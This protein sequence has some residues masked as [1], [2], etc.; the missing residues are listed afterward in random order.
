MSNTPPPPATP[1][2]APAGNAATQPPGAD[3]LIIELAK[4]LTTLGRAD[5]A[6]RAQAAAARLRRPSTVVCVVGEFKQGKSSLINSLLGFPVCPV[7][8]D[9]ATSA[10]T[11]VRYGEQ[12]AAVV[13][14]REGD[15]KIAEP[16]PIARVHEFVSESGNPGN[17]KGVERV[18][19]TVPSALLKQ[20]L[21]VVDTPGM[22]G[23]GAGHAAATLAFL[24]FADGLIFASDA[25]AE[26]S[27]PEVEFLRRAS[28][29]CPTVLFVQTKIDL[30]PNWEKIMSLN[31]GHMER[32]GFTIAMV[33]V[34]SAL[35]DEALR[36]KDRAL[37]DLSR[38]P[39]V[40]KHL[41]D[42]VV[43]PAK[44]IA[45]ERSV[46]DALSIISQLTSG[47][48]AEKAA[49][50]DPESAAAAVAAFDVAKT[51]LEY[52]RGPAAKWS[53]LVGD[54]VSD[55][56]TNVT[57]QFRGATRQISRMMD[58]R[59]EVLSKGDEWDELARYL[60]TVVADEVTKVFVQLE[61]GRSSVRD[62]VIELMHDED[63]TIGTESRGVSPFDLSDLWSDKELDPTLSK[64]KKVL[65]VSL[66][67]IRG[68]QGGVMMFGML[69]SFLPTAAGVLLMS[70]PVLL[71]V[72]A[73][74]GSMGLAEDRKKKVAARRQAARSQVRQFM[75]DVQFE[76][77]NKISALV[78]DIQRDLRDEFGERLA[79]LVRTCTE[80]ATRVQQDSQKSAAERKERVTELDTSLKSFTR[81]QSALA[82]VKTA[83][84][85]GPT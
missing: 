24:P 15:E 55:L 25:S 50:A 28:E 26:L 80:S 46:G 11:M 12:P 70:N 69:G 10:I 5:L 30:F 44:A 34:S 62:E 21:V 35:R 48:Q 53:V 52:L 39:E 9:L 17:V 18:E 27:A 41:N 72:G 84:A 19:I 13:R 1:A 76:V 68:A 73:L 81:L 82:A 56:S 22:G 47:L 64:G 43:L 23:L 7:D 29:L 38:V 3:A 61:Q 33:A 14:R 31:K 77:G 78:R 40:V 45:T 59:I 16:V 51:R 83:P 58:E 54:R 42:D 2:S 37:N 57:F 63:L 74:F 85:G 71:G 8:D 20:G 66:T 75:D 4:V 67:T 49:A 79:E 65:G 36:R 6:G 60:Q 32:A